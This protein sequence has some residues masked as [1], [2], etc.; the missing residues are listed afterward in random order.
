MLNG[1]PR[2]RVRPLPELAL[3]GYGDADASVSEL[4]QVPVS[5]ALTVGKHEVRSEQLVLVEIVDEP[6]TVRQRTDT[7]VLYTWFAKA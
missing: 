6:S 2:D 7:G 5:E 4:V 1:S 3:H